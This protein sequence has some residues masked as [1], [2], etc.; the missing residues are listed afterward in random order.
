MIPDKEKSG[1]INRGNVKDGIYPKIVI[2]LGGFFLV[3]WVG[4]S[5]TLYINE[6][7]KLRN[8]AVEV[9]EMVLS[10]V[11]ATQRYVREEL[12]P[13][14]YDLVEED[15]F[16]PEGMSTTFISRNVVE[17]FQEDYPEYY[18]KFASMNPRNPDNR[19]FEAEEEIIRIFNEHPDVSEWN[20]IIRHDDELYECVATPILFNET[21]LRCH[22][23]PEDAPASLIE[24]YG[25]EGGFY[26]EGNEV[27]IKSVGVPIGRALMDAQASAL[28][29]ALLAG[30]FML[31]LFIMTSRLIK[32]LIIGPVE[33]LH[34]GAEKIGQGELDYR[35]KIDSGD[36]I[37][38]LAKAFNSMAERIYISH[39]E[40][41]EQVRVRTEELNEKLAELKVFNR[42]MVGRELRMVQLKKEI[43]DLLEKQGEDPRFDLE[44]SGKAGEIEVV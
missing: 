3:F 17:R 19:A 39:G 41:Q 7:T 18:F 34:Q 9:C 21:C 15:G 33:Q 32:N 26:L 30:I 40:L 28:A 27:A 22:G 14:M 2:W 5:I 20:G 37:E 8:D 10:Q 35:L 11:D 4:I 6:R 23:N 43:N 44:E 38:D 31:G 1:T 12:R 24:R 29:Y 36:E 16:V 25:D 13:V 42:T